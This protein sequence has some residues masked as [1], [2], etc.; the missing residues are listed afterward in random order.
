MRIIDSSEKFKNTRE[1]TEILKYGNLG[2]IRLNIALT[3]A[4]DIG[5]S[6]EMAI[7][8]SFLMYGTK[9]LDTVISSIPS[10]KYHPSGDV[11]TLCTWMSK[12][13]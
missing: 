2:D 10:D 7:I 6:A 11:M 12:I 1:T 9:I 5:C 4:N 8:A 13:C 3:K